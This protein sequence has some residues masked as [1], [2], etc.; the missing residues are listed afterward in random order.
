MNRLVSF[1][2]KLSDHGAKL[3]TWNLEGEKAATVKIAGRYGIF[4]D[5]HQIESEKEEATIVAHEG[6][7]AFTGSTHRVKSP[8]D[9]IERH[10]YRAWKWAAQNY[11]SEEDLD[12][13]VAAGYTDIW[14]LADYFGVTED[15][16]KKIVCWYTYEN[17][18]VDLYF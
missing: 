2:R 5:F 15:F 1:Y 12:A 9:S 7:H 17:M 11:I 14:A 3:Y 18:A 13:A 10:E 16:M 6:G 8:F 4:L